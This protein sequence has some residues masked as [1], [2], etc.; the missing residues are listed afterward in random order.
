MSPL[1]HMYFMKQ[2]RSE[3]K[4]MKRKR[5]LAVSSSW[6]ELFFSHQQLPNKLQTK[7][8]SDKKI[9]TEGIDWKRKKGVRR[10]AL[11]C[12]W[13]LFPGAAS[14]STGALKQAAQRGCGVPFSGDIQNPPGCFLVPTPGMAGFRH[15]HP[16]QHPPHSHAPQEASPFMPSSTESNKCYSV[17][18]WLLLQ[19]SFPLTSQQNR[20]KI[21]GKKLMGWDKDRKVICQLLSQA[22]QTQRREINV[23]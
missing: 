17:Q 22:E 4:E 5:S 16:P 14:C 15:L 9:P 7:S 12:R 10:E 2:E 18:H 11:C 8:V 21:Q 13:Q 23:I 6:E 3:K 1:T 20:E 19:L